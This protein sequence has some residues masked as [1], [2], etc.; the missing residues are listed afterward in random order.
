VD[1]ANGATCAAWREKGYPMSIAKDK[2]RISAT[3]TKTDKA[4]LVQCAKAVGVSLDRA[5]SA[6][7][8]AYIFK[9]RKEAQYGQL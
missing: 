1:I 9:R 6:I 2:A 4:Y 3:L 5:V 8:E 7:V